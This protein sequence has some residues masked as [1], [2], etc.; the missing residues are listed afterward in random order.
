MKDKSAGGWVCPKVVNPSPPSWLGPTVAFRVID[1]GQGVSRWGDICPSDGPY[2]EGGDVLHGLG[3]PCP[4]GHLEHIAHSIVVVLSEDK[5]ISVQR[6][7]SHSFGVEDLGGI[8]YVDVLDLLGIDDNVPFAIVRRHQ[9]L[10]ELVDGEGVPGGR[11]NRQK[12]SRN[13]LVGGPRFLLSPM[14]PR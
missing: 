13:H 11:R 9:W 1:Q 8:P 3:V 10:L 7:N 6:V 14:S 4:M 12:G 2:R 5:D